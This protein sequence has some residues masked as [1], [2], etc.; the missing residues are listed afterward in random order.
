MSS[1]PDA[2]NGG[3]NFA[4]TAPTRSGGAALTIGGIALIG[5]L[6]AAGTLPKMRQQAA[7]AAEAN[8]SKT[9][10]TVLT[11]TPHKAPDDALD[12]PGD[13]QAIETTVISARSSGYLSRRLVDIGSKVKAGDLLAEVESPEVADQVAQA[14]AQAEKSSAVVSQSKSDVERANASVKQA[15]SEISRQQA[16]VESAKADEAR[17]VAALESAKANDLNAASRVETARN[18]LDARIAD[19]QKAR[20]A[21]DLAQKTFARWERL[22]RQGAISQQDLDQHRADRDGSH[23][24]VV[25]ADAQVRSARSDLQAAEHTLASSKAEITAAE[26]SLSAARQTVA[27]AKIGVDSSRASAAAARAAAKSSGSAVNANAADLA[28]SRANARH[29]ASLLA[30]SR[31]TAPFNG[32]ITARNVEVGALVNAGGA[33]DTS[34]APHTGLFGIARTDTVR[35]VVSVPQSTLSDVKEGQSADVTIQQLPGRIF[36]GTV[37]LLSGA[38][39]TTTRTRQIEVHVA[40]A[41]GTLLPGMYARVKFEAAKTHSAL[42]IA[43]NT[44][45]VNEMGTQVA[46]VKPDNTVHFVQVKIGRDFGTELEILQGLTGSEKLVTAPG[47]DLK[48]GV[49]V[50]ASDAPPAK[51]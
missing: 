12:L 26:A 9:P 43:S 8:D 4:G 23:A 42:R 15:Q 6:L 14:Q 46:I 13:V 36:K 51:N 1:K 25:S 21:E 20:V 34:A 49:T 35:I 31:I 30:F 19:A 3:H 50:K 33:T 5:G 47:D 41:D 29:F 18:T 24:A 11:V 10:I 17:A 28:A 22:A 44:L 27:A 38:L 39:D 16:A 2:E 7:L 32:V 48:E 40:N 45:V 37:A